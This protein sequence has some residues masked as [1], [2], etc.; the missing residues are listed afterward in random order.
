MLAGIG[1]LTKRSARTIAMLIFLGWAMG[2]A[3][4][5]S[6][7][8]SNAESILFFAFLGGILFFFLTWADQDASKEKAFA[9]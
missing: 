5:L 2:L 7:E 1:M 6:N 3:G 9:K 8:F 4:S